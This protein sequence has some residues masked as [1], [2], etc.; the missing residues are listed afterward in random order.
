MLGVGGHIEAALSSLAL[1]PDPV[2]C[3]CGAWSSEVVLG[4]WA[5]PAARQAARD[6]AAT[7]ATS[8]LAF[9][10]FFIGYASFAALW[11]DT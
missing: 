5:H 2:S 10:I 8:R 11:P 9:T 4:L 3:C 6:A 7:R 1:P